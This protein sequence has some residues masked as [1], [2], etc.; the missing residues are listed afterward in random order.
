MK[1]FVSLFLLFVVIFLL[2]AAVTA[3]RDNEI[4]E[5]VMVIKPDRFYIIGET[6]TRNLALVYVTEDQ[7]KQGQPV[8]SSNMVYSF[9][10]D[11]NLYSVVKWRKDAIVYSMPL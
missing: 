11:T 5:H 8:W 9:G 2:N 10:R 7:R 1:I 4:K 6:P 3:S